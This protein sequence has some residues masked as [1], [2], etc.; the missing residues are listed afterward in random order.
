MKQIWLSFL[1]FAMLALCVIAKAQD[2]QPPHD[3][4]LKFGIDYAPYEQDVIKTLNWLETRPLDKDPEKHKDA[5]RFLFQWVNG[6]PNVHVQ[7]Y[8]EMMNL[9][10][11][12]NFPLLVFYMAGWSRYELTHTDKPD[13]IQACLA[14]LQSLFIAY[15]GYKAGQGILKDKKVE[16]LMAMN[17]QELQQW[18]E[19]RKNNFV[20]GG[21]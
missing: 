5:Y 1:T 16:K 12:K 2:Y 20:K 18:A 7:I 15:K 13:T 6:A 10:V 19:E 17:S 4:S 8:S 14:G 9:K 11:E 21:K 3:Y